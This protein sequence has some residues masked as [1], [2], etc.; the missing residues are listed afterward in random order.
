MMVLD[1]FAADDEA[2]LEDVLD[3]VKELAAGFETG[4]DG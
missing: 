4:A 2:D 3:D 1:A